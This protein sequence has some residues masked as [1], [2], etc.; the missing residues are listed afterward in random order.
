MK[1]EFYATFNSR[2]AYLI[3]KYCTAILKSD[4]IGLNICRVPLH[5]G[6]IEAYIFTLSNLVSLLEKLEET[7]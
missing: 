7:K 3:R 1:A 2:D 4:V 6:R 5:S